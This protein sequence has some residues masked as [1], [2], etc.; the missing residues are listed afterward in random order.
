[1]GFAPEPLSH[2][3][4]RGLVIERTLPQGVTKRTVK[5]V[6]SVIAQILNQNFKIGRQVFPERI[7]S[8]G[9]KTV[10]VGQEQSGSCRVAMT[11]QTQNC[12]VGHVDIECVERCR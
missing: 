1:M 9:R 11:A 5:R 2:R 12:T 10:A 7:V 8:I 6:L 4:H 3:R